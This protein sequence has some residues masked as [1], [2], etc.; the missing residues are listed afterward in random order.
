MRYCKVCD[1]MMYIRTGAARPA[2]YTC[3]MCD[4]EELLSPDG[5]AVVV[6]D[7]QLLDGSVKYRRFLTPYL[8]DDVTVPHVSNIVCPNADKCTKPETA[9]NDVIVVKYD[10]ERLKYLYMCAHCKHYWL[11]SSG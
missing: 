6:T 3:K 10:A 8:A 4:N 7:N 11:S 1:N 2:A 9:T 5:A